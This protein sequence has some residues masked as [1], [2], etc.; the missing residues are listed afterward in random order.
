MFSR[1]R[2][3]SFR[4][5]L[6]NLFINFKKKNDFF[7]RYSTTVRLC[8]RGK[9]IDSFPILSSAADVEVFKTTSISSHRY[10]VIN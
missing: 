4:A 2:V 9:T 6:T 1:R 8:A 3:S 10:K 7:T 5:R